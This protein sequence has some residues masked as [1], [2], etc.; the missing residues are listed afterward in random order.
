[1]ARDAGLVRGIGPLGLAANL[2]NYTVGAGIFVVPSVIAGLAGAWGPVTFLIAVVAIA[3]VTV[4]Y[5]EGVARVPTSGGQAGFTEPVFGRL[6]AFL[7]GTLTYLANV[8]AAG[9]ITAA[10]ADTVA[11]LAPALAAPLP[12]ALLILAWLA[13]LVVVN[14][15]GV[16]RATRIV[17]GALF[18]KLVP[19]ALFLVVGAFAVVPANLPVPR[20]PVPGGLGQATLMAILVF[21][22]IHGPLLAAGE[23]RDPG[24]TVPRALG[25]GLL[26]IAVIY[27]GALVVAQGI[28]GDALVASKTPLADAIGRVWLPLRFVLLGGALAS[29]LGWTLSDVLASPRMLFALARDGLLP[30]VI[31]GLD[32][33]HHVPVAAILLHVTV[34]AVLAI[35][36]S[37]AALAPV[38]ALILT[39]VMLAAALAA[40]ALRRRGIA[41]GDAVSPLPGL[42]VAAPV[43]IAA[44]GWVISQS[45]RD[46]AVTLAAVLAA[47]LL[48]YGAASLFRRR[49][50]VAGRA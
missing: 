27:V 48:W 45:T 31:G 42:Y 34:I 29:M 47:L 39:V 32:A 44:M 12:R 3:A 5:A 18:I 15:G 17:E 9:A 40:L 8:L 49:A 2:V 25:L 23:I 1:M 4:C 36:G 37:F 33:R 28:L 24:R 16:K 13:V 21:A 26:V 35:G 43:A 7:V 20:L 46:Q 6:A 14:L 38:A 22:G 30:P 10:A 50:A 19:L 11:A 41:F